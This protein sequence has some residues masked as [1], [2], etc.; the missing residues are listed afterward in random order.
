MI[1]VFTFM[2]APIAA[3]IVLVLM[4]AY[5][6]AHI[7]S[8]GVIFVDLALAQIAALGA[9]LAVLAGYDLH[10]PEALAASLG[11][12]LFGA[13]LFALTRS[14][15]ADLPH[16]ALIGIVYVVAAAASVLVL[17]RSP[18]GAEHLKTVLV[19]QILW[20]SW[21]DVGIAS[22]VYAVVGVLHWIFRRR[23]L[24]LSG[25][26]PSPAGQQ[27]G[28]TRHSRW[29]DF[30]FYVSFGLV[31]T[32]SVP[33]AGVLLVFSFLIVPAVCAVLFGG[34]LSSRL[35]IAWAI[36]SA[37]SIVGCAMSF[38]FDT[39]TGATIVCAFGAVLTMLGLWRSLAYRM[40]MR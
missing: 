26:D 20:V 37:V 29:W 36:G 1:D 30:L 40:S 25:L 24:G 3:C 27:N 21:T 32:V 14:H 35:M 22:A 18:H 19:G 4:H 9:A 28:P 6:G 12:T 13:G 39:P 8:R 10:S 34:Q 2:A 38:G 15:R 5:L 16:E 23:F 11:A 31:I 17:D 7:L 33:I